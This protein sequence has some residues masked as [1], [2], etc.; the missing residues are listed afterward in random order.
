MS[1][2]SG[3][4]KIGVVRSGLDADQMLP[5]ARLQQCFRTTVMP[6]WNT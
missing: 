6:V 4:S 1:A 2:N 3:K 5:L